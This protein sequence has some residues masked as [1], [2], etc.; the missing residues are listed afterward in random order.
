MVLANPWFVLRAASVGLRAARGVTNS[1]QPES[2]L[3]FAKWSNCRSHRMLAQI[4]RWT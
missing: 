3:A 1:H 4:T 2:L